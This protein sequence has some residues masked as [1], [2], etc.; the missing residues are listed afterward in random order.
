[1]QHPGKFLARVA[2]KRHA[3][4]GFGLSKGFTD[5]G[6]LRCGFAG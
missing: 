1:L 3:Y 6:E 2:N 4:A 5:K